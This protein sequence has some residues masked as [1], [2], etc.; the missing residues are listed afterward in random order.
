[1]KYKYAMDRQFQEKMLQIYPEHIEDNKTIRTITF[2]VTENCCLAC[3]YCYQHHKT[4]NK[5]SFDTAKKFIDDLLADKYEVV[6][7]SNAFGI[8]V[9]FI[10]GEPFMEVE[11]IDQIWEYLYNKMINLNH[12][13]L[14]NSIMSFCSNGILILTDK[15]QNFLQKYEGFWDL[16]ISI[17]GNKELHDTCRLDYESKGSYDRAIKAVNYIEKKYKIKPGT[18]MTFAPSNINLASKAL[19]SLIENGYTNI[20]ANCIFES[21]WDNNYAA[22]YYKELKKVAN[23]IIDNDLY[24]K[25]AITIFDETVGKP[26]DENNNDNWC[27]GVAN[28]NLALD[29]KGDF[30]TCIR[31][32][33]SSLNGK[34]KPLILG[35]IETGYLGTPEQIENNNLLSNITR[36]S[37]STDECFYCPIA[38]GCAWCSAFNYEDQGTPN[39]RTTYICCMHKA[40][41]LANY[42]YWNT[43][44]KKLHI[45]NI[46]HYDLY[47]SKNECLKI[48][49]LEEYNNLIQYEK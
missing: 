16:H 44:Y 31:Y 13:W 43:L 34:Q 5:M 48:I 24:N 37:Q 25:V 2:Q 4:N 45:N 20:P 14:H 41:V 26:M 8:V 38:D 10:G 28:T 39:K 27:G 35:N 49:S 17:D 15:V 22:I 33:E 47:L 9:E 11:L 6:N 23:Y 30:Y 7:T 36:R 46:H 40:R 1:M 42:Y 12:P 18:K 21:G 19:I 3:S 32:M 29:Y